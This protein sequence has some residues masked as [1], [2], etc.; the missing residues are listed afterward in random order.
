MKDKKIHI[1]FV[2]HNPS[3][4][5][6]FNWFAK[7][8]QHQDKFRFTFVF[9]NE[10]NVKVEEVMK[11]WG[12]EVFWIPFANSN[13]KKS[14]VTAFFRL[15]RLFRKLRPD[16]MHSHLFYDGVIALYA[17]KWAGIKIRVHTKQS[18]G[19]NWYYAPKAVRFDR[20]KD[21]WATHLIAVSG[22]CRDF[23]IEK[24]KADKKKITLIHH[25]IDPKETVMATESQISFIRDK[26]NPERKFLAIMVA[27]YIDW[28]GYKYFIQA[29]AEVIKKRKDVVFLAIGTGP[30]EQE[31]Q[32]EIQKYGLQDY[33]ILTG[34]IQRELI[35]ACYQVADIYV[36][37][38][39]REPFGFVIPEAMM[40]GLP[41][42][43]T[44]TGAAGDAIVHHK[45]GY[46]VDYENAH[47]L[48]EGILYFMEMNR[49]ERNNM[50]SV[51]KE[52]ALEM[53]SF[54][55]MWKGYTDLYLKAFNDTFG[56]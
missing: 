51:A 8:A 13:K 11:E 27:R 44:K 12:A 19:F 34:F 43:T 55:K 37:A 46:L 56:K 54:D 53:F 4:V 2:I 16:I 3:P 45:N 20:L 47:Q 14:M 39:L 29:A 52:T 22:E 25:G 48:A 24:E 6:Y 42:V 15:F 26:Y 21:K 40:N 28:K 38:A 33:F 36:H 31:L 23:L 50:G 32:N 41:L 35:P 5:P 1:V 10:N 18:T 9:L 7:Y 49:E 30:Q 17:A